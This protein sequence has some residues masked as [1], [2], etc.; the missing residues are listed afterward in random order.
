MI[1]GEEQSDHFFV[2]RHPLSKTRPFFEEMVEKLNAA[3]IETVERMV[4][5]SAAELSEV[6]AISEGAAEALRQDAEAATM[7]AGGAV[8]SGVTEAVPQAGIDPPSVAAVAGVVADADPT[9][10]VDDGTVT[11]ENVPETAEE[12]EDVQAP[13]SEK[14]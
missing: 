4:S 2:M 11:E 3:G 14:E 13:S 10:P 1:D 12:T 8:G 5:A 6:L 7:A 9:D